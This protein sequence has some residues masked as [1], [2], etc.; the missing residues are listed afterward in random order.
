LTVWPRTARLR[1]SALV[2]SRPAPG[3]GWADTV[4]APM[5]QH[6]SA[7][8]RIDS[9]FVALWDRARSSALL[10]L[11]DPHTVRANQTQRP[12]ADRTQFLPRPPCRA[13]PN[14]ATV[15]LRPP[16]LDLVPIPPRRAE[17][18]QRPP[19]LPKQSQNP[20]SC[21]LVRLGSDLRPR[22]RKKPTPGVPGSAPRP[23][24]G[25]RLPPPP[26]RVRPGEPAPDMRDRV[27]NRLATIP[28]CMQLPNGV[29]FPT[30]HW[31]GH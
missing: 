12:R 19:A 22:R 31:S 18:T 7:S 16:A 10:A 17:R 27:E 28:T 14:K 5:I 15:T 3:A 26:H 11:R 20:G 13:L 4:H 8:P 30:I 9:F 25:H 2:P 24:P 21:G 23:T 1:S 6:N 29:R